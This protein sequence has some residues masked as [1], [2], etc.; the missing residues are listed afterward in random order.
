MN[1]IE[2]TQFS[3]L[4]STLELRDQLLDVLSDE[5]LAFQLPNNMTIGELCR[6]MVEIEHS[7]IEA[8]KT[9]K[10][11]FSYKAPDAAELET[12]VDKLKTRFSELVE[13]LKDVLRG[14]SEE[15]I[16]SKL[17]D[18]GNNLQFPVT[19]NFHVY[20][21]GLLIFY[22]KVSIYLKA[23]GKPLP[24]VWRWWIG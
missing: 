10:Q 1:S 24:G 8:F 16:Q 6:E 14:L 19:V 17:I 7:Y 20:R 23:M 5:D 18:R 4:N 15:D 3:I 11:D 21:E 22:A 13:A 12:S 9:Y 2:Q